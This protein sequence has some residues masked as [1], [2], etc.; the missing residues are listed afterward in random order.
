[1]AG[2]VV[3]AFAFLGAA[4]AAERRHSVLLDTKGGGVDVDQGVV[5]PVVAAGHDPPLVAESVPDDVD[6]LEAK[7]DLGGGTPSACRSQRVVS[8]PPVRS[9]PVSPQTSQVQALRASARAMASS[10]RTRTSGGRRPLQ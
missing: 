1:V 10:T 4:P 7:P 6:V 3:D 8:Q 5:L 9:M 2:C